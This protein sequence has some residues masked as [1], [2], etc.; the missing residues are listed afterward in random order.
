M[1][2]PMVN[3]RV[4]RVAVP[5]GQMH[6]P[7][8]VSSLAAPRKI[9]RMAVVFVVAVRMVVVQ[10]FMKMLVRMVFGQVQPDAQAHQRGGNPE[11][12]CRCLGE[13]EQPNGGS[14]KRGR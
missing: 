5:Y 1:H 14:D 13:N 9:M 8:A 4:M 3:I 6:M 2:M 7:M 11:R 10:R 12:P